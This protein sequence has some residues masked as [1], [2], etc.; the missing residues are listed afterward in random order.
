MNIEIAAAIPNQ[1]NSPKGN[2]RNLGSR[3]VI[4]TS[5][6]RVR[7]WAEWELVWI[8]PWDAYVFIM[9][10]K[11]RENVGKNA[12]PVYVTCIHKPSS[13]HVTRD[14]EVLSIG[15]SR[16]RRSRSGT[17]RQHIVILSMFLLQLLQTPKTHARMSTGALHQ[18]LRKRQKLSLTSFEVIWTQSR[19]ISLSIPTPNCYYFLMAT[20]PNCHPTTMTW[21]V[22]IYIYLWCL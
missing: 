16:I 12:S 13:G 7:A 9:T 4:Y 22:N 14:S 20:H 17:N 6:P 3:Q 15:W 10:C 5:S 8:W 2:W 1:E 19:L 18:S 21:Y 11:S